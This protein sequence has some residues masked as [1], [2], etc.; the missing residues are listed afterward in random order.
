MADE[1]TKAALYWIK[2]FN[3]KVKEKIWMQKLMEL[4][5]E[6]EKV[7][8]MEIWTFEL[9]KIP[10]REWSLDM[11]DLVFEPNYKDKKYEDCIWDTANSVL[12]SKSFWFIKWLVENDKIDRVKVDIERET[13][14]FS[15][16]NKL[17][18]LLSIQDEPI[19]FLCEII[20]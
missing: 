6:Y 16:L 18:M 20:K 1:F 19:R 3:K 4:L 15:E 17:I 2:T 8:E 5:N 14:E 13:Y 11:W 12:I 9:G 7:R 10:Y